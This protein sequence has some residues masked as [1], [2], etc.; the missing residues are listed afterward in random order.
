MKTREQ[1]FVTF[2]SPG[3]FIAETSTKPIEAWDTAMAV[4]MAKAVT[5]RHGAKPYIFVFSTSI[6]ADPVDD[7]RGGT[8]KVEPREIARSCNYF[9]GGNVLTLD[10]I[11]ARNDPKENILVENMEC[12]D[13]P[14][15]VENCN[16]YKGI[17]PFRDD[18]CIVSDDGE[19]VERGNT[20]ER[21]AYRKRKIAEHRAEMDRLYPSSNPSV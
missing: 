11:K 1:H 20:Q 19:V 6:V 5:E 13:F 17:L 10:D 2:V 3:T 16:S 8:L 15:V 7:G 18:D 4:S 12:N 14:I 9:I 21:V